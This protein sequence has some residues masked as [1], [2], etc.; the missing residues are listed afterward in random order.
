MTH[1]SH[2]E[3]E[4]N[5]RMQGSQQSP[6][7]SGSDRSGGRGKNGHSHKH[8]ALR[9]QGTNKQETANVT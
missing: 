2:G 8:Y 4:S 5:P 9:S 7:V 1:N 3:K 6:E